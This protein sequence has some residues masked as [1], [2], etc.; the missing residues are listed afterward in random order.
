MLD[1]IVIINSTPIIALAS[2]DKL[3][4]LKELYKEVYIPR[5]VS[6][7][8]F[9]KEGSKA[10]IELA[11]AREWIQIR[12]IED[13]KSKR[14]FRVQLHD[15]EVEVMILGKE[16]EADLLVIDDYIARE[17]AKYLDF[18]VTGTLGVILKAKEKGI[19]E[20]VKPLIDAL[21]QNGI[22]IG[23]EIYEDVL[24]SAGEL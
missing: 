20:N 2:I 24:N 15:G 14:F 3:F 22:Y 11:R 9:A 18:K 5:A 8:V 7:E 4:L 17:Y 21:I 6:E 16:L 1:R 10:Q 12:Q 23:N 13:N 19:I